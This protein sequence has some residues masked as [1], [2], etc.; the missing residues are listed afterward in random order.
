VL[1]IDK[2]SSISSQHVG[3]EVPANSRIIHEVLMLSALEWVIGASEHMF[4]SVFVC[5]SRLFPAKSQSLFLLF[6]LRLK[7]SAR[8][9]D[10]RC[11]LMER[12]RN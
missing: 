6:V 9:I 3:R 4:S 11:C 2:S 7:Q 8:E 5:L 10:K 12:R 1:I